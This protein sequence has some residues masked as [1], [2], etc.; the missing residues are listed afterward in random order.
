LRLPAGSLRHHPQEIYRATGFVL[1]DLEADNNTQYNLFDNP[2]QAEK[3]KELY[4]AADEL[5]K[6]FGKHTLHLGSSHLIEKLGKGRR[7]SPTIREQT[8]VKGETRR[9]H[10]ALPLIHVKTKV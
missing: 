4:N 10:L 8:C 1:L 3:I 7:C 9:R 2:V 6:R 5:G